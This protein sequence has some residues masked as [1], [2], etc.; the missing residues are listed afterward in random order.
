MPSELGRGLRRCRAGLLLPLL[1]FCHRNAAM[2]AA[3][4]MAVSATISNGCVISGT[5]LGVMGALDFGSRA[6]VGTATLTASFV[7]N[8]TLTLACTPGT[9]L[10][11]SIN[12]GS[13]FGTS[14]NLKV[15][16]NT[17]LVAYTLYSDAGM[18]TAIPVNQNVTIPTL[19]NAN[20]ITLPVYGR[21]S[22][23]GVYR[24]GTYSDTLTVTLTW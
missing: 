5:N 2:P 15:A 18:T 17:D 23:S 4:P 12:G 6:G 7:K 14:R 13:N 11:M 19:T 22:L 24:A 8:A 10:L 21:L 9:N 1:L 16:N 20:N 3:A